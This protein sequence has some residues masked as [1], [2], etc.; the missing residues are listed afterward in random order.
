MSKKCGCNG[1]TPK[2]RHVASHPNHCPKQSIA[3]GTKR[4]AATITAPDPMDCRRWINFVC[5]RPRKNKARE[6][7]YAKTACLG[8]AKCHSAVFR[9]SLTSPGDWHLDTA[10]R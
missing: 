9:S 10:T 4:Q 8:L 7:H 2:D 6:F 5:M 3:S 1:V